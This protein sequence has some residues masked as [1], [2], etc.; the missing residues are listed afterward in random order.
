M[1]VAAAVGG[2]RHVSLAGAALGALHEGALAA[3][4]RT[5]VLH[6]SR[7]HALDPRALL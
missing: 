6:A 3:P 4:L 1:C 7:L 2:A 5:L